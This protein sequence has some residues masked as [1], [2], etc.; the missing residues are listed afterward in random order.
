MTAVDTAHREMVYPRPNRELNEY[1]KN[2]RQAMMEALPKETLEAWR[3]E[4]VQRTEFENEFIQRVR[5][6]RDQR[7]QGQT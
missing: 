6:F 5:D 1:E 7:T 2:F 3:Q 4:E